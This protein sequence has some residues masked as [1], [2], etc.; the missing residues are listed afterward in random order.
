MAW[1]RLIKGDY[2][3]KVVVKQLFGA[4]IKALRT[5]RGISQETLAIRASLHRTYIS[6]IER[7]ARNPSLE[8]MAQLAEALEVAIAALVEVPPQSQKATK[9]GPN[10]R[11][12]G[13]RSPAA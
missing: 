4:R 5:N 12:I 2:L 10:L 3:N 11:R 6:D 1:T 8:T 9:T 13:N 7:G